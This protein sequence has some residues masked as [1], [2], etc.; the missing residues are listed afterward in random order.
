M[1]DEGRSLIAQQLAKGTRFQDPEY[2]EEL[3]TE[4]E[5]KTK[6]KFVGTESK[7]KL[8]IGGMGDSET[9]SG[10]VNGRLVLKG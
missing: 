1:T 10:V 8:R 7:L 6:R 2:L 4:F 9:A 5:L 3:T